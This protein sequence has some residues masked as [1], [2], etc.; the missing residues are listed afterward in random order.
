MI[1]LRTEEERAMF[2]VGAEVMFP[3]GSLVRLV[4]YEKIPKERSYRYTPLVEENPSHYKD[5][6]KLSKDRE[7]AWLKL[8]RSEPFT[9]MEVDVGV[10]EFRGK[11]LNLFFDYKA[12]FRVIQFDKIGWHSYHVSALKYDEALRVIGKNIIF[13]TYNETM[14]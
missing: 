7:T 11:N 8:D 10:E 13:V 2:R 3:I 5:E 4:G 14:E 12:H 9:I 6:L 1:L